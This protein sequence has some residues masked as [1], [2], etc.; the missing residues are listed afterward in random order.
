MKTVRLGLIGCGGIGRHHSNALRKVPGAQITAAAD[1]SEEGLNR[2]KE[3]FGVDRTYPDY[4]DMLA[5][6]ELDAVLVCVPTFLHHAAAVKAA[7]SG[8]HV[9]CEKPM[10]RTNAQAEEMIE[11]CRANHVRLQIGF[12]RRF[13]NFW[14][15]AKEIVDGGALGRTV[16][17]RQIQA[18]RGPRSWFMDR[19]K[20]GGPLL[21]G[22]IHN[23]DFAHC[24]F[25]KPVKV[26]SGLTRLRETTAVDTGT[27]WVDYESGH[28]MTNSW[29]WGLAGKMQTVAGMDMIGSDGVLLFPGAFDSQ[30]YASQFDPK[31]EGLF[32]LTR[33]DAE[34]EPVVYAKNDMFVDQLKHFSDCIGTGNEPKVTGEDGRL[35]LRV[36]LAA[37]QEENL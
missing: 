30:P 35:A 11:A 28:A 23:I 12:V 8:V 22:M 19:E 7:D 3:E 37:L 15:K 13:D 26:A 32:L 9:F 34:S 20:G 2:Y 1:V 14:G 24:M 25:G 29:S 16:V 10:A 31:T 5:A 21:D 4:A 36:A 18:G 17:W 6:E 33:G 27:V